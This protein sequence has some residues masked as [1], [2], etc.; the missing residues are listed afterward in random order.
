MDTKKLQTLGIIVNELLTNIMKHAFA[1]R[2]RGSISISADS[3]DE[4]ITLVIEDDGKGIPE[5]VDLNCAGF[6]LT[7]VGL[8]TK[9][10]EGTIQIKRV[11]GTRIVLVFGR[12]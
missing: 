1:G 10:L 3:I 9:Q 11:R 4:R 7:L 6:G 12:R 2:E 8:L 5:S